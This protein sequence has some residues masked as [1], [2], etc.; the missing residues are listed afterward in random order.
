MGD[1]S[2]PYALQRELFLGYILQV[3]DFENECIKTEKE[4]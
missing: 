4:C 1:L 2:V 3:E